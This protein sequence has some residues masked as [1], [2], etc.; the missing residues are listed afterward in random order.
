MQQVNVA[1]RFEPLS[2]VLQ[3]SPSP[4]LLFPLIGAATRLEAAK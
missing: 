3:V 2:S 1:F 4:S